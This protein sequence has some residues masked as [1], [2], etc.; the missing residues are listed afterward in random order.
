[1]NGFIHHIKARDI[2]HGGSASAQIKREL[3]AHGVSAADA[4]RAGIVA[5]EGEMNLIVYS[6]HGGTIE[7]TM[8]P[9][10][11]DIVIEDDGPGIGDIDLALTPG[12]ST[13]PDWAT[14]L[15][16]GAGMGLPNM[17]RNSDEFEMHSHMGKGTRIRCR[18]ERRD[19]DAPRTGHAA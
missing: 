4:R 12:Y 19:H 6:D 3:R 11:V 13:C 7:V 17:Q 14:N 9:Q 5:F 16:F 10:S 1:V 8:L 2:E 18:I 15:G